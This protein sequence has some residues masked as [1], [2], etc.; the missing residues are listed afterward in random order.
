MV[1][2]VDDRF[3]ELWMDFFLSG[4]AQF[5]RIKSVKI[6]ISEKLMPNH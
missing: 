3:E 2:S 5:T 1:G 6:K 4:R